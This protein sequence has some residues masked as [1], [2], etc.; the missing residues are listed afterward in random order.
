MSKGFE[1][2]NSWYT[3]KKIRGL[4]RYEYENQKFKSNLIF[5]Y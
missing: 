5:G 4:Y 1:M 3:T 2:K